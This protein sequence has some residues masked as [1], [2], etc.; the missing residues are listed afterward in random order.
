MLNQQISIVDINAGNF[1]FVPTSNEN[2]TSYTS[3]DFYV[4]EGVT[5][6]S[7]L[8]GETNAFTL[9]G[10]SLPATDAI[11][12]NT[13]NFGQGGTVSTSISVVSSTTTVD[14]AYLAQGS[15]LFNGYVPD[16]NWTAGELSA[17]DTWVQSGG[18]LIS[19]SDSTT[20]DA[21]NAHFGL[22]TVNSGSVV[23]NVA[24]ATNPIMNGPFGLVGNNGD[25]FSAAGTIG[26]FDS[27]SLS[28]GDQVLA[29]DSISGEPT[30]VLRAHG[31]GFILFTSDEG[32]FRANMSGGGTV[33]TANDV[34]AANV[35]AWAVDEQISSVTTFTMNVDVNAV[36]DDP[37]NSGTLPASITATEDV[38]SNVDLSAINLSDVDSDMGNLTITL[39]TGSG[40]T[41]NATSSGGVVVGGAGSGTLTLTGTQSDLNTFLDT[42]SNVQF[43]SSSNANGTGADSI[44]VDVTDNGNMGSG[45]GG[46]IDLGNI[47]VDIDAENDDPINAGSLPGSV[48][49][50][51]DVATNVDFSAIDLQDVDSASSNLTMTFTTGSGGTLNATTGGGV[52][53]GGNGSGV[54]TLTGTQADLNT[55]LNNPSSIQF[56]GVANANGVA[57]DS[58][59]V[60]VTDNGNIGNGGGGAILL[61]STD[62]DIDAV[63]DEQSLDTNTNLNLD[64][65][66]T[67]QIL[68]TMLETTDYDNSPVEIVY[69]V[70]IPPA[71]GT[72]LLLG[73]PTSSFTQADVNSGLVSYEHD[74]SETTI[75]DFDFAVDDGQGAVTSGTFAISINSLNDAPIAVDDGSY[76]VDE[77]AT[78]SVPSP[79]VIDNDSDPENNPLTVSV[80]TGPTNGVLNMNADGS[81]DY[82]HDGSETTTDSFTYRVSDGNGGEDTATVNITIH[83]IND[84]PVAVTESYSLDEDNSLSDDVLSND[85][86]AES[87]LLT[88]ELV[89]DASEGTLTLN[90]NGTFT[91]VPNAD[92][93]GSD[94]FTYRTFDGNDRSADATVVLTVNAVN[95]A[96][97]GGNDGFSTTNLEALV[98]GGLGVLANDGDVDGDPVSVILLTPPSSGSVALAP[99]GTF[100]YTPDNMFSGTT[101]FSY[102][103][104]DGAVMSDPVTSCSLEH[105][106]T[107]IPPTTATTMMM[108]T[109][110][111]I[112]ETTKITASRKPRFC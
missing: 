4:N 14:A 83:P 79:G 91:Y 33:S 109:M 111:V 41:L 62:I 102:M 35:I 49:V 32:V 56:T 26:Y 15:V 38:A 53:V 66:A 8:A 44:Q 93:N 96:P 100:T 67:Q 108:A 2:G 70:T 22:T 72:L 20:Y 17:V 82:Q 60:E 103:M 110:V 105:P 12:A 87:D 89:S 92:F 99:N 68:Q 73:V 104:T 84:A 94:S 74:G 90:S 30:I 85:F 46:T 47:S 112:L 75:D 24:D 80:V 31:S 76:T 88:A 27:A 43:V 86:D 65:G 28:P 48:T 81:F 3:F 5:S 71:N 58:I 64:E 69:T 63:N 51:E 57:A 21:V 42:A 40:G 9:N 39:T 29:T 1:E 37:F 6:V 98:V 16:A 34:L 7:I 101:T 61:G 18:I 55:F 77:G 23:W 54:L 50:T 45:G 97:V 95:D 19:T 107:I 25:P 78:L 106:A 10:G 36:N 59:Q 13:S 52:T 11:L